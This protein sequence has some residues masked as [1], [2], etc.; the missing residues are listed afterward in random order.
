MVKLVHQ[1]GA[2]LHNITKFGPRR[3]LCVVPLLTEPREVVPGWYSLVM[4]QLRTLDRFLSMTPA[5]FE[6]IAA[7]L[8][9][10]RARLVC[11]CVTCVCIH[12]VVVVSQILSAW[13]AAGLVHGD[14]KPSNIAVDDADTVFLLDLESVVELDKSTYYTDVPEGHRSTKAY[15]AP[16][17]ENDDV[18]CSKSDWFSVGKSLEALAKVREAPPVSW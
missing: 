9:K 6:N 11:Q 15:R 12:V 13:E 14:L 2:E 16:E 3:E 1:D 8:V 17:V 18:L 10:V 5:T 7:Q 4:P